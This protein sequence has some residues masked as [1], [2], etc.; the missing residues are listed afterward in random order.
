MELTGKIIAVLPLKKGTSKASG[1][2][3]SAQSYVI[4]T[5][6]E[7]PTRMCFDVFGQDRIDNFALCKDEVVT[8]SFDIDARFYERKWYNQIRAWKVERPSASASVAVHATPNANH[9]SPSSNTNPQPTTAPAQPTY[10]S[11]DELP[12]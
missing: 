12:F 11:A 9:P 6:E 2:V 4:E 3:W 1:N 5:E 7:H 8:V 10:Q